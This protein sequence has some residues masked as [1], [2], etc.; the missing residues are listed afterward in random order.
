MSREAARPSAIP[1]GAATDADPV[2]QLERLAT[3]RE[4]GVVTEAEFQ[5]AKAQLLGRMK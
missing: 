3:L 2:G 5:A 1:G 4:K